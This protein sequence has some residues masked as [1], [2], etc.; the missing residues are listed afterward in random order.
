[1]SENIV[2]VYGTLKRG[3]TNHFIMEL[4]SAE[5]LGEGKTAEKYPL[6]TDGMLPYFFDEAGVGY[7]IPVEIYRVSDTAL[8]VID[9]FECHPKFYAR[10]STKCKLPS[11]ETLDCFVYFA[12]GGRP[13][14]EK[15]KLLKNY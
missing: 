1:M 6:T 14:E 8:A 15:P 11:G 7:R 12:N 3:K 5:L 2:A 4:L 13:A 10:K 9:R